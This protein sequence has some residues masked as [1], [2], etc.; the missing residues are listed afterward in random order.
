LKSLSRRD[1]S[2]STLKM[3]RNFPTMLSRTLSLTLA[4]VLACSSAAVCATSQVSTDQRSSQSRDEQYQQ[5]QQVQQQGLG[6]LP[7]IS[8]SQTQEGAP[9]SIPTVVLDDSR[10][11]PP[12]QQNA[13][14]QGEQNP[15]PLRPKPRARTVELTDFQQMVAT[16]LGQ[17]LPIYG[18][19]LFEDAPTTFA[20]VDH[21]PVTSDYVIG[22]GDELLIRAW[23]QI[24]L[25]VHAR[26]DRNGAIYIPRVGSLNVAGLRFDQLQGFLKSHIGHIYQNF[27]LN[28]GMG[29]LRSIDVFVVGQAAHPGRYTISSLSTLANA[30]FASG[31]PSTSGSMRH[32]ELKRSSTM[33]TDFDLYDL[34]IKGDKSKDVQLLPGDVIYF[35]AVG[36][37]VAMGGEVNNPAIYELKHEASLNEVLQ[38][39]GGLAV[40]AYGGKVYVEQIKN[41]EDRGIEEI[42]LDD[43]GLLRPLKDGDV[44]NF[45]PISPRFVDSV[46]L[47]G[48]VAQPGRYPWR[49]GMRVTD[50]IPNREFLITREYWS[51]QNA[52]TL[53]LQ[54]NATR[55]AGELDKREIA[56]LDKGPLN[57]VRRN[58]P[59]INWDYAV[60]QRMNKQDL[61]T[62]LL[63][64]NLGK[65]VLE[66]Q[67]SANLELQPGDIITIFSQADLRVPR[68]QQ[69][70]LVKLEGEFES[71]GVYRAQSGETLRDLVVRAGGMAPSAYLYAAVFTRESTRVQQQERLDMVIAQME[72]DMAR[73]AAQNTQN[74]RTGEEANAAKAAMEAQRASLEKMRQLKA[75]G[76]IILTLH[77]DDTGV[78]SIPALPLEDGDEFYIPS[79][80][81]V[82]SVVGDVYNQGSFIE[83]PGKTVVRY[84]RDAG[85]PTR[86]ADKGKIFVVRANGSVVSKDA[87]S[88]FWSGGFSSMVLMPGDTVVVPEQLNPGAAFRNFKD[89]SQILFN[90]GLAAAA[91]KV[92]TQ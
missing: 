12:Q 47:R 8:P 42:K 79:R 69:T 61:S 37:Q 83:R 26:V 29:E 82:V 22:P 80:P 92:L 31:G 58:A 1:N 62:E 52:L 2:C 18:M 75:D 3:G 5:D 53:Q 71:A 89:W 59:E 9:A 68:D 88:G 76:R 70:K 16:S 27:D 50:L 78:D 91:V 60:V 20:P 81:I 15:L 54:T 4:L 32:I 14:K 77:P 73:Q 11:L 46:T 63:P 57:D 84:L 33:V 13:P 21:A 86:N 19:N 66:H 36:P 30:I 44:L 23:G 90:F 74:A 34:L 40:T 49:E 64:F 55:P 43:A 35:G 38:M 56:K 39:A 45:T 51:Q 87:A 24:D 85:G 17:T 28:V 65:A 67:D 7:G 10:T 25:D 6:Q 72:R 48:N 41:R